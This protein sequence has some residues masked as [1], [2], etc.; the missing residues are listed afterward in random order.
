MVTCKI[1]KNLVL[2]GVAAVICEDRPYPEAVQET[3]CYVFHAEDM[4]NAVEL[5]KGNNNNNVNIDLVHHIAVRVFSCTLSEECYL[6]YK[7]MTGISACM[8]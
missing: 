1:M 6:Y 7:V 8:S 5:S 3:P 4:E 2:I